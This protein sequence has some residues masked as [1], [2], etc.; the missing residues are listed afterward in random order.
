MGDSA[1]MAAREPSH[2]GRRPLLAWTLYDW[3][4][5]AFA[6]A[7]MAAFFPV[8]F[9]QFWSAGVPVTE[10]TFRLG[11]ANSAASLA[12]VVLAP[13]LGAIADRA[14][15][16]KRFLLYFAVLG[17]ASTTALFFVQQGEW[18]LAA[19]L[20]AAAA[21]GFAGANVFY[22]ALL[23]V[24]VSERRLD[25][26]SSL[27]YA[28]GY[29]GGGLSF[30]V[31]VWLTV[32][33]ELFGLDTASQGVRVSFL[34]VAGWWLLFSLPL[35]LWVREPKRARSDRGSVGAGL[36]QL[37]DTFRH[38]RELRMVALFLV[39]YWLYIDGVDTV[40][41]MAIDYGLS[42]GFG[43]SDL[44]LALLLT[45]FVGFPSALLFGYIA[46]RIGPKRG[47]LICIGVYIGVI[48]WAY[49]M[50]E[51][52]EFYVLAGIV[53]LVQGGIQALSRS[54][55]A[56][57]IPADK[58]GEFFGFYNM[59]GK[60]AAVLGPVLMGVVALLSGDTRLALLSTIVLFVAGAVLLWR[61][62]VDAGK[63]MATR[64]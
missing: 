11:V 62:D 8:F 58:S 47:V 12:I 53:G 64:L 45:Q 22:D 59:L 49:G 26:A 30:G 55:Y 60:F 56:R 9:K 24:L 51:A 31:C 28:L 18:L 15:A 6:T 48:G 42:L 27:G 57:L 43:V 1:T 29:L 32:Q 3:G 2:T 61:V 14:S 38:L 13:L 44:M 33:P 7:V 21:I 10:S 50:R 36:R 41:R 5:S 40:V 52:W 25:W 63:R 35:A 34:L 46:Q 20:Y 39:A 17:I 37:R 54:L 4:N 16:R 19:L 23:P